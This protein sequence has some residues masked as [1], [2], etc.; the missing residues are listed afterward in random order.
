MVTP[1]GEPLHAENDARNV[2]AQLTSVSGQGSLHLG[3]VEFDK[4]MHLVRPI[5]QELR[6]RSVPPK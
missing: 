2:S 5:A 4:V 6:P 3:A 1:F